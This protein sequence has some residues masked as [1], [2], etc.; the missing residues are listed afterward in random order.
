MDRRSTRRPLPRPGGCAQPRYAACIHGAR[1]RIRAARPEQQHEQRETTERPQPHLSRRNAALH[2]HLSSPRVSPPHPLSISRTC[3]SAAHPAVVPR[4]GRWFG[5]SGGFSKEHRATPSPSPL[6]RP[7][8]S[9]GHRPGGAQIP[10]CAWRR[11]VTANDQTAD[12][13]GGNGGPAVLPDPPRPV[14]RSETT[15]TVDGPG[16]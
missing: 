4:V 11:A 12:G 15:A 8:R 2:R 3:G 5:E 14:T 16:L 1:R 6:H 9:V 13:P 10:R 7:G